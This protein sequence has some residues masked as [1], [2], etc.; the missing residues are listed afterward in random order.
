ME[1]ANA[2]DTGSYALIE[3][4]GPSLA[5]ALIGLA[6]PAATLF[7]IAVLY[8]LAAG[9]LTP[10]LR[11]AQTPTARLSKPVVDAA[12]AGL[13]YIAR[14]PT[15]RGLAIC[16]SVYQLSWG[17]L[18]VVVPVAVTRALGSTTNADTMVGAL[19]S[20]C[21]LAGGLGALIAG[22][23]LSI[24][25]ERQMLG[26][27]IAGMAVA[28]YPL[29]SSFG[30]FGLVAGLIIMG[31]LEGP[32]DVA[33]LTLRQ[34][35]TEPEWL[36]RVLTV[37]MSLNVTGL[38][39]GSLIGGSLIT[40]SL[41]RPSRNQTGFRTRS[42][43]GRANLFWFSD[44]QWARIEPFIPSNRRGVKPKNNRRILSGIM[45]VLKSGCRW[46]DCP[47]EYGPAKTVYNRFNRWSAQGIWQSIFE[48]AAEPAEPPERMALD[49]THV[50][51]HRCAGGGKGGRRNRRLASPRAGAT[52]RFTALSISCAARGS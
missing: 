8:L 20:V 15:L 35:R 7:V 48:A 30:L 43:L 24:G 33:L 38:P 46:V 1:R 49:S 31:F 25:R 29:A 52:A 16:Y 41:S 5:G 42:A 21:G 14:H 27:S 2:L 23:V 19:W 40:H 28:T 34:R 36:G 10:I 11:V 6:G 12:V 22:Q 4:V 51:A 32:A 26:F 9:S 18:V 13:T 37:S 47:P 45:H 3:V 44:G 39:L 50:K 17:V